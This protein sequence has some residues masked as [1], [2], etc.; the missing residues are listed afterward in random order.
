MAEAVEAAPAVDAIDA[1]LRAQAAR[2]VHVCTADG[3]ALSWRDLDAL[4]AALA[5]SEK[6]AAETNRPHRTA[7]GLSAADSRLL[8]ALASAFCTQAEPAHPG[9]GG[10]DLSGVAAPVAALD[11]PGRRAVSA[12]R[13]GATLLEFDWDEAAGGGGGGSGGGD[14]PGSGGVLSESAAKLLAQMLSLI[15]ISEP[16]RPY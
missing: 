2:E 14:G 7:L 6:T 15:H 5:Q 13:L 16:T 12:A 3:D 11:L 8:L 4:R 10:V 1:A 9:L